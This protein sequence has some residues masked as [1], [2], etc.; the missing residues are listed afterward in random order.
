MVA[1]GIDVALV[2]AS[3]LVEDGLAAVGVAHAAL[4]VAT[5]ASAGR[6]APS[7]EAGADDH[8][9][10]RTL[11]LHSAGVL[12]RLDA[13]PLLPSA[14]SLIDV[15]PLVDL[16]TSLAISIAPVLVPSLTVVPVLVPALP[17][18]VPALA[19]VPVLIPALTTVPV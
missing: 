10:C 4:V 7:G 9:A 15:A 19:V 17:V 1:V 18:L 3:A 6:I 16:D 8:Q 12:V 13:E 14:P 11:E 2:D 5:G